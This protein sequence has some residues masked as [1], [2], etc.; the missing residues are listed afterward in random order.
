MFRAIENRRLLVIGL[1]TIIVA[2]TGLLNNVINDAT[3][4]PWILVGGTALSLIVFAGAYLIDRELYALIGG[5]VSL[6]ILLLVVM[7]TWLNV[8]GNLVAGYVLAV[9][10]LPFI[11]VWVYNRKNWGFLI[12]GYVLLAIIPTVF[13]DNMNE[14]AAQN[15]VP[16]YSLAAVALP[17]LVTYLY[18]RKWLWLVPGGVLL[19]I[20]LVYLGLQFGLP[21][22]VMTIGLPLVAILIGAYII[23]RAMI[24][25]PD[26]RQKI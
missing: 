25:S 21:E 22:I 18:T 5:Y 11:F 13:M 6:A 4:E 8:K 24:Q 1:M 15:L 14:D 26:D 20:A 16:A 3:W 7:T 9:I 2:A 17:F 10:A 23:M 12:P 19:L